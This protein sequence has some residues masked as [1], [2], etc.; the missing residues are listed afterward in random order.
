MKE[1]LNILALLTLVGC[2][3]TNT[4]INKTRKQKT[5]VQM[6]ATEKRIYADCID[7][8]KPSNKWESYTP[9]TELCECTTKLFLSKATPDEIKRALAGDWWKWNEPRNVCIR[10]LY[11]P[12]PLTSPLEVYITNH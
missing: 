5:T 10:K 1:I 2:A 6:S 12:V 3:E 7:F 9:D 11:T 4:T 8:G